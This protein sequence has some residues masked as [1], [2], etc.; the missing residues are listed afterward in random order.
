MP[1]D[2]ITFA[3]E[4]TLTDKDLAESFRRFSELITALTREAGAGASI[5]WT[6]SALEYGS[7]QATFKGEVVDHPEQIESVERV[8]RAYVEV[9]NA[10][11]V[12]RPIPYSESV[13]RLARRIR[14]M[15]DG[16]IHTARFENVEGEA[17]VSPQSSTHLGEELISRAY[18]AA[19]GRV[20]TLSTRGTLRFILY[21]LMHD[22]AIS[23]YLQ[24]GREEIMRDAWG[25]LAIV[26][27]LITRDATSGRPL[28]IRQVSRITRLPEPVGSWRDAM[29]ASPWHL[30][31]MLPEE[32]IRRLRDAD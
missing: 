28:T 10:L 11:Q 27:G 3:L 2:T 17:I 13:Q 14:Q 5:S 4:G 24:E 1:N 21:D 16:H 15:L 9:G 6:L 23:C 26:E 8:A 30:G 7:A 31:R 22:R 32:A 19:E 12:D 25:K 29:G 20:Q 18:G